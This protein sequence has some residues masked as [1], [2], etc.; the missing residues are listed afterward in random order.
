M[1]LL[2]VQNF[3]LNPRYRL[4]KH[5]KRSPAYAA[6]LFTVNNRLEREC[7]ANQRAAF[8]IEH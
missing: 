7:V 3:R 2:V 4:F 8:V 1:N 6:M 5:T